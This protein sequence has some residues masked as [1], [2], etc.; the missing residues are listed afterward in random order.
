MEL[1]M[2]KPVIWLICELHKVM[3]LVP[4]WDARVPLQVYNEKR[5]SDPVYR[6]SR[7]ADAGFAQVRCWPPSASTI[8]NLEVAR[9]RQAHQGCSQT[10]AGDDGA[11][12]DLV[13]QYAQ[14]SVPLHV[15]G[16]QS[17]LEFAIGSGRL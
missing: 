8:H 10:A 15:N 17:Y 12:S 5:G 6:T 14:E 4:L 9:D 16:C 3:K 11:S 2:C 13:Q 7:K 1:K